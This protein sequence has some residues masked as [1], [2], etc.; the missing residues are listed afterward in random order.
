MRNALSTLRLAAWQRIRSDALLLFVSAVWGSGFVAQRI[1]AGRMGHFTFNGAR[2]LI[3]ALLLFALVRFKIRID[4]SDLLWTAAAG[5]ILFSASTL[6]QVGIKTTT[7]GN[8]GFITGLYV[9]I[10]PILLAVFARQRINTAVWLAALLAAFGT[11]L[12]S[13]AGKFRP[14]PGDWIELAGAFLWAGHVIVVGRMARRM[15]SIQFAIGQFIVC[16]FLNVIFGM[17]SEFPPLPV[18]SIGWITVLYSAVLPIGFG[19]TLQVVAQRRA[20]PADAA[21]IFSM[22]AVFASLFGY[23]FLTET[24]LPVQIAGCAAIVLAMIIAQI[25]P[26][27]LAP[28]TPAAVIQMDREP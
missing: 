9:V 3:A 21:I 20:P 5:A 23:W 1:A 8:A 6:Q 27:Q 19:F 12:L 7:A 11:M 2:F 24:L 13:T 28:K 26:D 15:D 22:E 4:R 17:M 10:I 14:A 25:R 16:G 18:D